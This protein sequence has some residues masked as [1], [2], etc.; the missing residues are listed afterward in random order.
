MDR[1]VH[2]N[3]AALGPMAVDLTVRFVKLVMYMQHHLR[4]VLDRHYMIHPRAPAMTDIQE[5]ESLV[6]QMLAMQG[7][8][9]VH[10]VASSARPARITPF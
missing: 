1:H 8:M 10:L 5:M 9:E 6:L 2:L 3:R 7:I 4:R